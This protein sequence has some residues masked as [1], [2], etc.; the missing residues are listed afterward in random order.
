MS[1]TCQKTEENCEIQGQWKVSFVFFF[2]SSNPS[3]QTQ[4]YIRLSLLL[5]GEK[6]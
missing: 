3:L 1:I 2:K 5:A 4:M 6:R